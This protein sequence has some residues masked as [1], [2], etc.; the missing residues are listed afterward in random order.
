MK[1]V[2][3]FIEWGELMD[4]SEYGKNGTLIFE[5][6]QKARLRPLVDER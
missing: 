6:A 2:G 1:K 3:R 5:Q 4:L